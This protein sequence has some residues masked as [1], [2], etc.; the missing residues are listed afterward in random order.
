MKTACH[1]FCYVKYMK[2]AWI[3]FLAVSLLLPNLSPAALSQ[4]AAQIM[5]TVLD[6]QGNPIKAAEVAIQDPQTGDILAQAVTN[7]KGEYEIYGLA[8]GCYNLR[9][10]SITP[11]M[12]RNTVTVTVGA[13]EWLT[14]SWLVSPTDIP[15]IVAIGEPLRLETPE[16]RLGTGQIAAAGL[17]L[18]GLGLGIA[19]GSGG[20]NG[21]PPPPPPASPFA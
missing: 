3:L 21:P 10:D 2:P 13:E 7:A 16:W 14:V 18:L 17:G 19:F 11:G 8:P 20:G 12:E 6:A 4:K 5:G 1:Q 15:A 9:L